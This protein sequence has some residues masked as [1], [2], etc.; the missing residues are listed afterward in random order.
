MALRANLGAYHFDSQYQQSPPGTT[1][2][3]IAWEWFSRYDTMPDTPP[4]GVYHSWDTASKVEAVHDYSVCTV[5]AQYGACHYLVWVWRGKVEFLGLQRQVRAMA[6]SYPPQRILIEDANAGTALLQWARRTT[7]LPIYG[8]RPKGNKVQR[9]Y[10]HLPLLQTGR[11]YMPNTAPW[12]AALREE[13]LQFPFG[14][15]DDQLDSIAQYLH[16]ATSP[17]PASGVRVRGL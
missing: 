5:W 2:T 16:Y 12:C 3:I 15:H 4:D 7:D 13:L 10:T 17:P 9:I 14:T 1:E 6:T 8:I 11:I